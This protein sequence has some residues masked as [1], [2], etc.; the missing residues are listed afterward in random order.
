MGSRDSSGANA[1][2]GLGW[3][4]RAQHEGI[5]REGLPARWVELI[6]CLD[7]EERTRLKAELRYGD[8]S[9]PLKN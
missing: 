3:L 5:I 7:E 2:R 6:N 1:A 9:A 4:L 8:E